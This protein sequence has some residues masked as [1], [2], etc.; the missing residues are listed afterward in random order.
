M[1]LLDTNIA[2]DHLRGTAEAVELVGMLVEQGETIGA[3]EVVRFELLAGVRES[4]LGALESFCSALTWFPVDE[5]VARTAGLL[6]R[7][8]AKAHRGIRAADYLVAATAVNEDALLL[9]RNVRH[10]PM[11]TTLRP[12]Y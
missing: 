8:Y 9:T 12:P 1:R 5:D 10:F 11:F 2:I 7:R 3:S 4:E 6:A